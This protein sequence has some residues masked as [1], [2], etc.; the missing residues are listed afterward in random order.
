MAGEWW[1]KIP[2]SEALARLA[3]WADQRET[4]EATFW[5]RV[6]TALIEGIADADV[7]QA[8]RLSSATIARRKAQL[9]KDG[10]L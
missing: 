7:V 1:T 6:D 4:G 8:S 5:E 10:K 2:G 9:R 3:Y